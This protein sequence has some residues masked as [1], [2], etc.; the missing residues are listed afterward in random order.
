M[1]TS[2][3]SD[4]LQLQKQNQTMPLLFPLLSALNLSMI[5]G[6]AAATSCPRDQGQKNGRD[7]ELDSTDL[8]NHTPTRFLAM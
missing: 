8:L 7:P 3:G 6:T 2:G 1:G 5:P 4:A